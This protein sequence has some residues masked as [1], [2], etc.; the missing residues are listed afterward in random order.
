MHTQL[1]VWRMRLWCDFSEMNDF[2]NILKKPSL[3]IAPFQ[4]IKY[5]RIDRWKI[6]EEILL[7]NLK[8][9]SGSI[10]NS[11]GVWMNHRN[12][13][14]WKGNPGWGHW[15][16]SRHPTSLEGLIDSFYALSFRAWT[17][18][19]LDTDRRKLSQDVRQNKCCESASQHTLSLTVVIGIRRS[20]VSGECALPFWI[21]LLSV[22][23]ILP[24]Q[25][26]W[27]ALEMTPG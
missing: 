3:L 24:C 6:W 11:L 14:P 18:S 5:Y 8:F 20:L 27:L 1:S 17:G 13:A 23:L 26:K 16:D 25:S 9:S 12:N 22:A 19:R 10:L 2:L 21:F 15:G 4:R 7:G